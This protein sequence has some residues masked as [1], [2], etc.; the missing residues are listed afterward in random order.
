MSEAPKTM[1]VFVIGTRA[2]LIKMAPVIVAAETRGLPSILLLSGQHKETMDDLLEEFGIAATPETVVR[3]G[4]RSTVLSLIAWVPRVYAALSTRLRAIA[5]D[6]PRAKV[7]VHGDTLSTVIGAIAARR[8][9]LSVFHVES[10]LTSNRLFDPFPEEFSRRIVF[11]LASVAL[12]PDQACAELMGKYRC[13]PIDTRGNT[14]LDSVYLA[15]RDR[16]SGTEPAFVSPYVVASI[17][18]FQNIFDSSRFKTILDNL[19]AISGRFPVHFVLHPATRKRLESTGLIENLRAAPGVRL[20]SRMGYS[21]FL[22]LAEGAYCVLTDGGSNQEELA[23][24]GVPTLI[25]RKHTERQD[26]L[27]ENAMMEADLPASISAF[28]LSGQIERLRCPRSEAVS[29]GPSERI[30]DALQ[31]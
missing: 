14:I 11:H 15:T 31:A 30:V 24:L 12:C 4:E 9:G 8:R 29:M 23:V 28:V 3:S 5:R 13:L 25:L 1:A 16:A 17:H 26:G 22:R 2:Q 6:F 10:G 7:I 19:V 20:A 21:A 27:G 18:R